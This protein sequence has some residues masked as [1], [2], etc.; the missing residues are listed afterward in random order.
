MRTLFIQVNSKLCCTANILIF[1]RLDYIISKN[2][3]SWI[4]M[5]VVNF[6][7]TIFSLFNIQWLIIFICVIMFFKMDKFYY[8]SILIILFFNY[9]VTFF[10]EDTTRIFS[11]LSWGILLQCVFYSHKLALKN[12]TIETPYQKQF[13]QALIIIGLLS[14]VTPHYYSWNGKIHVTPFYEFMLRVIR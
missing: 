12:N 4:N 9:G 3:T 8:S 11:L 1:T 5:N 14:I 10:T 13:I 7:M 2:L 6:P